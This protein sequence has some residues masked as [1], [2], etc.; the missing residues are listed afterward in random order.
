MVPMTEKI[1][2][3]V[4]DDSALMRQLIT[5]LLS[6]DPA[7]EVVGT[8]ADPYFARAKIK[9]LAP[10]VLTLDVEMPRM[11]GLTFLEKLMRA[12]P[13]PVLMV[14]ALTEKGCETTLRALELG[15]VDFV[16]KPRDVVERTSEIADELIE[17]VKAAAQAKIPALRTPPP[18]PTGSVRLP[19][20]SERVIVVAASTGGTEALRFFLTALPADTPGIVI[21]QHMPELFTRAFAH[22]LDAASAMRVREAVD[23]DRVLKGHALVAPG[24]HHVAVDRDGA[25]YTVKVTKGPPVNHHRP[26]ADVLFDSCAQVAGPQ[27]VGIILTGMGADGARG[28]LRL[29]QSGARTLAQDEESSVV[30]GM[31]KAAI[32]LGAVDQVLP[33]SE[34]PA[35]L[36][37]ALTSRP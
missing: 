30:F 21:V 32:E 18:R 14:S 10:D 9:S 11:D 7:I 16:T 15:A 25:H 35:A 2:V 8:A 37:A 3:L 33:L 6:R 12:H 36:V 19:D 34:L 13:L 1:K 24:N 23:G 22:R 17:K 29:K 4:V 31:P 28:L 26:S 27:A 5:A 20:G